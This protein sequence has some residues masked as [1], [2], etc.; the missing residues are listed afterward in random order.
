MK[1]K[2]QQIFEDAIEPR[3][4]VDTKSLKI[5]DLNKSAKKFFGTKKIIP[6]KSVLHNIFTDEQ[7]KN[8]VSKFNKVKRKKSA[9]LENIKVLNSKGGEDVVTIETFNH[10]MN[11][12]DFIE[13]KIKF[14]KS[15]KD[16]QT[17]FKSLYENYPLMNFIIDRSGKIL[18]VNRS[19]AKEL[20]Y[21]VNELIGQSVT[22]VFLKDDRE[23]VKERIEKCF[24]SPGKMFKWKMMKVKKN[25]ELIWVKEN[26]CTIETPGEA[27]ELL[28]VCENITL[29]EN[30]LTALA[31]SELKFKTLFE[32]ANDAIFLMS[33]DIFIDCNR[34]T[35]EMFGCKREEILNTQ[36]HLFSPSIQPDGRKSKVKALE[37]INAALKG[38]PQ[39]FEWQHKKHNG[40]L[41]DAE[42][43]LN[44]I[45]LDDKVILQAIVRDITDSKSR[46]VTIREQ[47]RR[48]DTLIS[49]LPGMAYRCKVNKT[50]TMELVSGGCY[51]L[52]GYKPEDFINGATIDFNEI[53]HPDDRD[54]LWIEINY[55]I[56]N[57]KPFTVL[58]RIRTAGGYEKW[59]WEKGEAIYNEEE[60]AI[61]LE[62][63]ITDIT[64]RKLAEEKISM[65]A[66]ALK[67]ISESV[68]ITDMNDII[69]FVNNSFTYTYGYEPEEIIGKHVSIIRSAKNLQMKINQIQPKTV[70]GG[71]TGELI[72]VKKNG[73]EFP[74]LLSTSVIKDDAEKPV[75]LLGISTDITERKKAEEALKQS[76]E[77]FKSLVDNMLEPA[78]ILDY[79][80][81]ILF[82]NNSAAKLVD[83]IS[84]EQV[85][86]MKLFDFLHPDYILP[87][88]RALI[89]ASRNPDSIFVEFKIITVNQNEKW[90][91]SLGTKIIFNSSSSI[92][93]TLHDIS[94]RK[95]AEEQLKE[96]KDYAEEMNKLKSNFLASMSHELRTPLV[97]ILGYSEML[98]EEL[99]NPQQFEMADRI[100]LSGKRLMETLN[101]VLDL[102]RIEAN[103][104][105]V[106]LEPVNV[107]NIV[108]THLQLF[109]P[110]AE[111]KGLYLKCEFSEDEIIALLDERFLGQII[112]NLVNNAVKFTHDGGVI[113]KV[114]TYEK[115]KDKFV[116]IKISDTGIG[117]P[118]DNTKTIFEEF[119]QVSEGFNRH[120]EGTGLGLTI[121]KRFIDLMEGKI[122]VK[123]EIGKG[124]EFTITFKTLPIEEAFDIIEKKSK[125]DKNEDI[126]YNIPQ[127]ELPKVLM[128]ED[129]ESS[130]DV[131]KVFLKG[132]CNLTFAASG[133]EALNAVE[134][135]KFD[136]ILMDINLGSGMSGTEAVGKIK[137][138]NEYKD[139]PIVA[140]T[141]FAMQGDKDEF[142][143]AGCT[144]YISK[145]FNRISISRLMK[146]I[147]T[148]NH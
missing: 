70:E 112:N 82:A 138:F 40:T 79:S 44:R 139:T 28:I 78:L 63:F 38:T 55:A 41:F 20:G 69:T 14:D 119:R 11:G 10:R 80:G 137:K 131:T 26:A 66:H 125:E 37:K 142:L 97:G 101:S 53:I 129:D 123:S 114:D 68:C 113:V 42:V 35:L 132:I 85:L 46:E 58:Y 77:R 126:E 134:K 140:I 34:K 52:T 51:S 74:I 96:A 121:T 19:G 4:I 43:S 94:Q 148:N 110:V 117:I 12:N 16:V 128:V 83:M 88:K 62:G 72:N 21:K 135:E 45:L 103:Q 61:A 27:D 93:I 102:S 107:K 33:K 84:P 133:E 49:N 60:E 145:P 5:L 108:N 22:K 75:A 111:E 8:S 7:K 91:E 17:K 89:E 92:L 106:Y 98:K 24:A 144:H 18:Q 71:W 73:D 67:S 141:A 109:K 47:R 105:E 13:C 146:E 25:G 87:V 99:K 124:S 15:T 1:N 64:E 147:L 39:F 86:G 100:L 23:I 116:R 56:E 32:S 95:K 3:I 120:F 65:L 90:I 54:R 48:I 57:K 31:Q 136:A 122:D 29:S 30:I 36:L 115:E 104:V 81:V 59:L 2:Y 6:Q 9:A 130:K 118:K 50:W 127:T 143:N 76:E